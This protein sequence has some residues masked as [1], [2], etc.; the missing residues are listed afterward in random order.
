MY[1]VLKALSH[2]SYII[3]IAQHFFPRGGIWPSELQTCSSEAN[4]FDIDVGYGK[5]RKVKPHFS[6]CSLSAQCRW[7][8]VQAGSWGHLCGHFRG[9]GLCIKCSK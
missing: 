9:V 1:H 7:A 6:L 8:R 3:Y 2:L 5:V 4:G